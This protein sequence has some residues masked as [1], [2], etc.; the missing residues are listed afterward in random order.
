MSKKLKSGFTL[1]ELIVVMALMGVITTAIVFL[2]R[3]TMD[4]FV[5][6]TNKSGEEAAAITLFDF[7]NGELR[8]STN[9]IIESSDSPD[10]MPSNHGTC[11]HFIMLTNEKRPDSKKGARGYELHGLVSNPDAAT[12]AGG[13][14]LLDEYDFQFTLSGYSLPPA[15]TD[16]D[17]DDDSSSP[18]VKES[19]TVS[20]EVHPMAVIDGEFKINPDKKYDFGETFQ[21]INMQQKN[22]LKNR[23][24]GSIK[25]TGYDPSKSTMWIFY[26][27]AD[28]SIALNDE[29]AGGSGSN[30]PGDKTQTEVPRPGSGGND[31]GDEMQ[32]FTDVQYI[33]HFMASS[34]PTFY[35]RGK[36]KTTGDFCKISDGSQE[37][38]DSTSNSFDVFVNYIGR[39]RPSQTMDQAI[40]GAGSFKIYW[41][42]DSWQEIEICTINSKDEMFAKTGTRE[43]WVK[44]GMLFGSEEE[45]PPNPGELNRNITIH[46]KTS[47]SSFTT[48]GYLEMA[49]SNN[50]FQKGITIDGGNDPYQTVTDTNFTY[51]HDH[52]IAFNRA[53][54]VVDLTTS[55]NNNK[56]NGSTS[57]YSYICSDIPESGLELWFYEGVLYS[58]FDEYSAAVEQSGQTPPEPEP[59]P[60]PEPQPQPQPEPE[61][62]PQPEPEPQPQPEPEPQPGGEGSQT[63]GSVEIPPY[64]TGGKRGVTNANY[65]DDGSVTVHVN[66]KDGW[67]DHSF[68]LRKNTDGTW[69]YTLNDD[70]FYCV[71]ELLSTWHTSG[72]TFVL[73]QEQMDKLTEAYGIVFK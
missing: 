59:E 41:V 47:G 52:T 73:S 25:A 37:K 53:S 50:G 70:N 39:K 51:D 65:N 19:I 49:R 18:A 10:D 32:D 63:M 68:T 26:E 67:N 15:P 12:Y 11:K 21:L 29:G 5:D 17:D 3:P 27:K 7:I 22:A 69:S 58:S 9:V 16:S 23:T 60:Q 45:V 31:F 54:Q 61:P 4:V 13:S 71:S 48:G 62:Q 14:G 56:Y 33:I 66:D 57:Y 36:V 30:L 20:A 46:C 24:V 72:E 38:S 44:D 34:D 40:Y 6:S 8:Y 42:N 55:L 28:E 35:A 43:I 64:T 2:I 1:V